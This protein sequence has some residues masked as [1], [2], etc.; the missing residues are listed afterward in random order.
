MQGNMPVHA[1][2]LYIMR[3][4][5]GLLVQTVHT[6]YGVGLIMRVVAQTGI[7]STTA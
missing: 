7:G 3:A 1:R 5:T 4:S 6:I 2:A